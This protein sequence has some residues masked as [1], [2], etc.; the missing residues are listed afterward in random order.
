MSPGDGNTV[1]GYLRRAIGAG[2]QASLPDEELLER[3]IAR[4]DES[5]FAAL[6]RRHGPMVW[7]V[8]QRLLA[9]RQDAEDAFQASFLVL[10]CKAASIGRRKALANWLFGV[11]RRAA[12]NARSVRGR[13]THRERLCGDLPEVAARAE[14]TWDDTGAV[15]DEELARLPRKYRLPLLLCSLEGMTHAEAGASLG[16]PTGTVAGRLSR[17]RKL[18]RARLLRRGIA[19]PAAGL[20]FALSPGAASCAVPPQLIAVS[21]QSALALTVKGKL[22][23]T[24]VSPAVA[25]LLRASLA[26]M[27]IARLLTATV[28]ITGLVMTLGSAGAGWYLARPR[29]SPPLADGM[30]QHEFQIARAARPAHAGLGEEQSNSG[31]PS[32][33]LPADPNA[34]VFQMDRSVESVAGPGTMLTIFAD[35]RVNAQIPEGLVSLEATELTKHTKDRVIAPKAALDPGLPNTKVLTGKLSS[36][37]LEELLRFALHEQ[38]FFEFEPAAVKAG[39]REHYQ[40]DGIVADSTDATTTHFRIQTADRSHEVKWTRL[41]KSAWDFPEVQRL[42]QLHALDTRLQQ[43]FYVVLAGGPDRVEAAVQKANELARPL[44]LRYPDIPRLTAGDLFKVVPDV[45]GAGMEWTFA[46]NKD[47]RVRNSLFE[48]SFYMP[49]EGE[50]ILRYLTPPQTTLRLSAGVPK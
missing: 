10:A 35:G 24:M 11:A 33:R 48:V 50:P 40:S 9:H 46:R 1:A 44:Y 43:V 30:A 38:E 12:L 19:V 36:P 25:A 32:L 3:F 17:G 20:G 26:R 21:I 2:A 27:F 7:G 42:L 15:L 23:T 4:R 37:E 18:L 31:K 13:R 41:S 5:A 6:L 29:A 34:V 49:Q 47:K 28:L 14:T 45:D 16:W 8:C 22:A 39:I